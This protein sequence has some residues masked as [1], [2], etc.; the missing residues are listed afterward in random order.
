MHTGLDHGE[1]GKE[2]AFVDPG[3][4]WEEPALPPPD[5]PPH[6]TQTSATPGSGPPPATPGPGSH[7][8][9]VR[10]THLWF[11]PSGPWVCY[12]AK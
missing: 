7:L 11:R 9:M 4:A 8:Q 10:S 2:T 12:T 3:E 5:P 1:H 6:R